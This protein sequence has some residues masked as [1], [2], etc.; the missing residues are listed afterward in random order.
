MESRYLTFESFKASET[1]LGIETGGWGLNSC[2]RFSLQSLWNPFRDWNLLYGC[3]RQTQPRLQSLWN[4]FRDWNIAAS[5][6][7]RHKAQMLQSLWNPFRDWNS[8]MQY[9]EY[10][11]SVLQSLW[12]P[13]RDWNVLI[14]YFLIASIR[15]K[16]SETL[17]GI[18]TL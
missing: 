14:A 4:P 13:F 2:Y 7:R 11:E 10:F 9:F 12:N 15:F 5:D 1:L 18:E 8:V 16:A 3:D 17:L 6:A